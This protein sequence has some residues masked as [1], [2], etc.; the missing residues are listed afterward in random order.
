MHIA[1]GIRCG[2]VSYC[3]K[4]WHV[5]H[6]ILW[7]S[8]WSTWSDNE[9]LCDMA[10]IVLHVTLCDMLLCDISLLHMWLGV[11]Y[12]KILC[13]MACIVLYV[14]WHAVVWH[15]FVAH[16]TWCDIMWHDKILYD[17]TCMTSNLTLCDISCNCVT[18]LCGTCDFVWHVTYEEIL[19]DMILHDVTLCDSM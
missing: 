18:F 5:W 3:V 13:D 12:D 19:C 6:G 9:I 17:M 14:V 1:C 16:M 7:H 11:T 10:Y 2:M 4:V 8:V 15:F